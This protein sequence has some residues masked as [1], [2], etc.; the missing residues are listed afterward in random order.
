MVDQGI[1]IFYFHCIV[2]YTNFLCDQ[3][4]ILFRQNWLSQYNINLL[5]IVILHGRNL[6][7]A[8]PVWHFCLL[9]MMIL[10]ILILTSDSLSGNNYIWIS[11]LPTYNFSMIWTHFQRCIRV[12]FNDSL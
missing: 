11:I 12:K 5:F 1:Y 3:P 8:N 4:V 9:Y 10:A 2:W 7:I 6:W